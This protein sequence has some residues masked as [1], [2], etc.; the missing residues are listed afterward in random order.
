LPCL[1][2]YLVNRT[3]EDGFWRLFQQYRSQPVILKV[4]ISFPVLP[5]Q[6]TFVGCRRIGV[7]LGG[8]RQTPRR[9]MQTLA[10]SCQR[11]SPTNFGF[12]ATRR[13]SSGRRGGVELFLRH[14]CGIAGGARMVQG[15]PRTPNCTLPAARKPTAHPPVSFGLPGCQTALNSVAATGEALVGLSVPAA[16][17]A[18]LCCCGRCSPSCW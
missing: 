10:A 5:Q 12:S 16:G 9:A 14:F 2:S 15:S 3:V 8:R 6:Q 18:A 1:F 7:L 11:T 13:A 4:R 17:T